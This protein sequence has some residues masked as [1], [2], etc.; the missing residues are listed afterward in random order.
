FFF[1]KQ[2][3]AYEIFTSLEFRRVLFRSIAV[4][5]ALI[6]LFP[7]LKAIFITGQ[8]DDRIRAD[9][10]RVGAVDLLEKPFTDEAL[11]ESVDRALAQSGRASCR[12]IV[13]LIVIERCGIARRF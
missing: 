6:R 11:L 9:A 12:V 13:Q 4:Y 1:F 5:E 2:K 8:I 10:E 3:T 7:N